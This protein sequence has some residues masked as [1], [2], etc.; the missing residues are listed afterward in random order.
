MSSDI[1]QNNKRIAK[2]TLA[3]YFRTFITMIV[4]LYTG[5]VMLQALGVDNYG[6]NAVVGGIVAMSSLI[7]STMS[8]AIGRYITYALGKGDRARLQVMF[9]TSINAQIVM[10][11]LAA[12]V[13]E[14]AGVWFL[15][16]EANI[17]EGRMIAANWVLHC[18]IISL[19]ISLVSTP[20][21]ALIV[22]HERMTIYAYMS[23]VDVTFK[24]AICF[25]IM[26]YGGDRLILLALLQVAVALLMRAFYGWYCARHFEEA[27][28]SPTTF[29]KGLLRELTVFSGWNLLNH[30]AYVFSTQGVSML[31]NVFFFFFY[32]AS[33]SVALTVNGVVQG[34]VGNFTMAFSPQITKSYAAG[35]KA[36]AILLANRGTKFTW[37]MM[38]IFIVPVCMEAE[39]LLQLWLGQ[40][41]VLAPL[42]LRFA[43]FES[44]AFSS[45][46]N[47]FKLVQAD[48]RVKQYNIHVTL[49]MGVIFPLT[50]IAY[51]MGAPVW[52]GYL[53]YII[54]F[55]LLN[56]VRFYVLK[57]LMTFS[58]KQ[59]LR[60]CIYP[61]LIVSVTSFILPVI[62]AQFMEQGGVR[63]FIMVP[64]SV[65]W[66]C[67]C[68]VVFGLS[69]GERLFFWN[70]M[71]SVL[72]SKMPK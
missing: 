3:L 51:R 26:M 5:R 69:Q 12:V 4:G 47:L 64:V 37:L 54:D 23:I 56:F 28:Y 60:D 2:N 39:T 24:L 52:S 22:A 13:L 68:C 43:M 42:F 66:T 17:P 34:F 16:S 62:L 33:R 10:A 36:Y 21:G 6:I 65:L 7:T 35:D 11:V 8:A 46:Q 71:Q 30:G 19:M 63:F 48:G 40:V 45:G 41:P 61:C 57:C 67:V 50:W 53:I 25:L 27:H 31:V 70:K 20:F 38:Y 32:N 49:F 58:V 14:V 15:N 55:F 59:H 44:L 72:K 9:S 1:S 29:D 18:S